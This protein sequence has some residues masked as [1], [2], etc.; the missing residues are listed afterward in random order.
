MISTR[1][2]PAVLVLVACA[3]VP[4]V[5]H[6]YV[7][8]ATS[9]GRQLH[10]IPVNLDGLLGTP[11]SRLPTWAKEPFNSDEWWERTYR[12][13]ADSVVLTVIRSY[14]VKSVY[15]HPELAIAYGIPFVSHETTRVTPDRPI[16]V[17]R[18]RDR[19]TIV[20][21]ALHYGDRFV[22]NPIRFQLRTA[23]EL[24]VGPRRPMTLFF[25]LQRM[26]SETDAVATQAAGRVLL[27]A[28][29]QFLAQPGP[30]GN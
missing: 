4:V 19:R 18:T 22:E 27:A 29:D 10:A 11:T 3:L 30:T 16:H 20:M 28:I 12:S 24:L 14:D 25:A 2:A 21:Y 8:A 15:H 23:G 5:M 1:Y 9:D 26:A 6:T 7:G 17:L 13:G